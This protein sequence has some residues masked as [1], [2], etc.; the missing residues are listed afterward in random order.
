[1]NGF[2]LERFPSSNKFENERIPTLNFFEKWTDYQNG[3]QLKQ[4]S[5]DERIS[6]KVSYM[7]GFPWWTNCKHEWFPSLNI[8]WRTEF[9]LRTDF[10]LE[11][12]YYMNGFQL[13]TV[14]T[15][16]GFCH[17]FFFWKWTHSHVEHFLKWMDLHVERFQLKQ[18]SKRWTDLFF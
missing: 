7:N 5:K 6:R 10:H 15:L 3:F 14:F 12:F 17:W 16:N 1:M 11:H 8:F 9:Q 2:L 18:I 13:W 4:F